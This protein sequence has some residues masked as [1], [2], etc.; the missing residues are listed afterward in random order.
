MAAVSSV[1]E[2]SSLADSAFA[3]N[4]RKAV[5]GHF[6]GCFLVSTDAEAEEVKAADLNAKT[7]R[8][9]G[10]NGGNGVMQLADKSS[11]NNVWWQ[12]VNQLYTDPVSPDPVSP[13]TSS[14]DALDAYFFEKHRV[15][16][17]NIL[18]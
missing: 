17:P 7:F 2:K 1:S 9:N 18:K 12:L 16:L 3:F 10:G 15:K 4:A 6:G 13:R 11:E 8:G 14:G 5:T